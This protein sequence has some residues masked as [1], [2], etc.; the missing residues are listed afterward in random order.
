MNTWLLLPLDLVGLSLVIAAPAPSLPERALPGCANITK[1]LGH[2]ADWRTSFYRPSGL[3]AISRE[4]SG[5]CTERKSA[6]IVVRS[7]TKASL[8]C[9]TE[10]MVTAGVR[11]SV[12]GSRHTILGG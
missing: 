8:G 3:K 5:F 10:K 4:L 1:D 9:A 12:S 11:P 7:L 6:L 2:G